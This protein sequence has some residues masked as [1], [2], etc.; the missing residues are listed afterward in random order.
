MSREEV[1]NL[2]LINDNLTQPHHKGEKW[3][4]KR[5]EKIY[6]SKRLNINNEA[7]EN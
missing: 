6:I 5:E 1:K 4:K 2:A 7:E 3:K